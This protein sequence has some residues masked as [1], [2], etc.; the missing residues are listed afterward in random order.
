MIDKNTFEEIAPNFRNALLNKGH[1]N[2]RFWQLIGMELTDVKKG[3]ASVRL[4][5]DPKLTQADGLAHGGAIFS[6]ADA[7]VAMALIGMIDRNST[8]VTLEM[9][10]NYIKPFTQGEILAEAAIVNKGSRTA[11]GEVDVTNQEG[12]L[13]AKCIATYMIISK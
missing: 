8:M 9:K 13:I 5:F 3:W 6:A 11:V 2:H 12:Q 7:A 10:I 1:I 4:P